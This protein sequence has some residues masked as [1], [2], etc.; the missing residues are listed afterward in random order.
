MESHLRSVILPHHILTYGL[1]YREEWVSSNQMPENHDRNIYFLFVQDEIQFNSK[2]DQSP[3]S[4]E[5]IPAVR[6]DNYSDFGSRWSPKVGASLSY[7]ADGK[8]Y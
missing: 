6:Y 1:G 3:M 8:P 4:I 7:G 2:I 5:I